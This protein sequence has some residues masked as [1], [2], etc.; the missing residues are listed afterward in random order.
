MTDNIKNVTIRRASAEDIRY[1][2]PDGAPRT[3]HAWL[4]LYKNQPAC[5]AGLTVERGGCVAYSE[6]LPGIVAPKATIWRT[7][8]ALMEHIKS[9]NLP[10]YAACDPVNISAQKFVERLGFKHERLF[11]DMELYVWQK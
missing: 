9:L 1:F 6:I 4:A 3:S 7:A 5:L 8:R 11:Q 2:Y 10:M